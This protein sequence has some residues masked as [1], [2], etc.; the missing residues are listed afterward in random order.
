M[1][2]AATSLPGV[3]LVEPQAFGDER[4]YFME[5]FSASRY[6]ESGIAG[7]FVQDNLSRSRRGVLRGIHFQHPY[8]Q[9]KLVSVLEGEVFDVAVDL[10]VGSPTFGR[11]HAELLSADNRRQ[12]FVPEGFGHA[13][14]VTSDRALFSYKCT[15]YYH[16]ECE[17][18]IRWDD[19]RIGIA[20]PMADVELSTKDRAGLALDAV[21]HDSLPRYTG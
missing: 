10:R 18:T 19:A 8:A 2:I 6:A 7:P 9:A 13:F 15:E 20:W 3:L 12:L 1:K 16:P 11:W 17:R 21:S 4:G 14:A 5:T